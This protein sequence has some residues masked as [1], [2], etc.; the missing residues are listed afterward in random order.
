MRAMVDSYAWVEIFKGS[1]AG[2]AAKEQLEA[3]DEAFTPDVVL[4]ELAVKYLREGEEPR[5]IRRWLQTVTEATQVLGI[6]ISIAEESAKSSIVLVKRA[7]ENGLPKPGLADAVV[8]ASARISQA[9]VL[10]GDQHFRGLPDTLWL[11]GK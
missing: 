2:K 5:A 1:A 11:G 4:A 7:G 10:T 8:L 3:S 9:Q 6:D